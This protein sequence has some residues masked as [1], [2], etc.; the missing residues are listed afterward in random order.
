[1][2]GWYKPFKGVQLTYGKP[3]PMDDLRESKASSREATERIMEHIRQLR[4]D[5]E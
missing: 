3:I 5:I 2:K 1:M 4:D